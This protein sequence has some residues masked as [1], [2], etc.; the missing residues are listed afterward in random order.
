[1]GIKNQ[2]RHF[3]YLGR[4]RRPGM[5]AILT[6]A[7][8]T[9]L[10]LPLNAQKGLEGLWEGTITKGG[11]HSDKGHRFQLYLEVN[12]KYIKGRSYIYVSADSIV[13]MELRGQRYNDN[14]IYLEEVDPTWTQAEEEAISQGAP[15]AQFSRKYQFI[16]KRSIWDPRLE[17]YW[18][19]VTPTPFKLKRE[20]GRIFL[21]R[22]ST[23]A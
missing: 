14:S 4:K 2:Y 17:G 22:K 5:K 8:A 3:P 1:M 15:P 13:Q 9:V 19:E 21:E 6:I 12:D 16:Y 23:K 10:F 7:L 18:Q 20:R 11:I